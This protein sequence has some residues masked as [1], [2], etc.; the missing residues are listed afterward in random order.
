[1]LPAARFIK[2]WDVLEIDIQ[3]FHVESSAGNRYLLLVV[4]HAVKSAFA[5]PLVTKVA[6]GVA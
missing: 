5:L 6:E 1:M 3:D 2:P 4:D